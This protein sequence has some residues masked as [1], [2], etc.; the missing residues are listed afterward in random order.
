MKK[1][2]LVKSLF[3]LALL[4]AATLG[5]FQVAPVEASGLN[6]C[7]PR[8]GCATIGHDYYTECILACAYDCPTGIEYGAPFYIVC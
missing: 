1:V 5:L 2:T 6:D 7:R 8:E 3:A 4:V